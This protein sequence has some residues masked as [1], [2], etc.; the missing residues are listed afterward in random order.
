MED[1]ICALAAAGRSVRGI[2]QDL[3]INR[4]KVHRVLLARR[5]VAVAAPDEPDDPGVLSDVELAY[6][7]W[8]REYVTAGLNALELYRLQSVWAYRERGVPVPATEPRPPEAMPKHVR[9]ATIMR[10]R[11]EGRSLEAIGAA[12]VP[13]MSKGGVSRALARLEDADFDDR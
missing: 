10:L 6:M 5:A 3:G 13:R 11:R 9:D 1:Q 7:G 4:G 2:A 12:V 8:T